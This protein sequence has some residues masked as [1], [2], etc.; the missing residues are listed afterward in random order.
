MPIFQFAGSPLTPVP[1]LLIVL[2]CTV[3]TEVGE[4]EKL[5]N[6]V[7]VVDETTATATNA[8]TAQ[9]PAANTYQQVQQPQ[10]L[11]QSRQSQ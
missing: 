3:L 7:S 5:G 8:P 6:P 2:A 1:R 9:Q 11:Q 4:L 10:Q